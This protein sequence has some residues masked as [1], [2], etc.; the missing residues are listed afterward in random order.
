MD[1]SSAGVSVHEAV[2]RA[3]DAGH[4]ITGVIRCFSEKLQ[5]KSEHLAHLVCVGTGFEGVLDES[6]HRSDQK[7]GLWKPSEP[8]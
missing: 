3:E 7:T 8:L 2:G 5:R 1:V 6:H 4:R